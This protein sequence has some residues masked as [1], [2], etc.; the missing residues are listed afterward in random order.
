MARD[1]SRLIDRLRNLPPSDPLLASPDSIGTTPATSV[2]TGH[3]TKIREKA[4]EWVEPNTILAK[5]LLV[6]RGLTPLS[7]ITGSELPE[8]RIMERTRR[9]LERDL[10]VWRISKEV[11][12]NM[13]AQT[14]STSRISLLGEVN[15]VSTRTVDNQSRRGAAV[16]GLKSMFVQKPDQFV[17]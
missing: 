10:E 5:L 7:A 1:R 9:H 4:Q 17:L 6:G 11:Q 2:K 16:A 8:P 15:R 14:K 3:C 12:V 13:E